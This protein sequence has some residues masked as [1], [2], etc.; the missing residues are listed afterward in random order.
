MAQLLKQP[1][2]QDGGRRGKKSPIQL[3]EIEREIERLKEAT[4]DKEGESY[5]I[6]YRSLPC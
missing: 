4:C 1:E 3:G 2:G 5:Y 6:K